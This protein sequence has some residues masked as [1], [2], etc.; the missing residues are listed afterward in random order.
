MRTR[1]RWKI[2]SL[3]AQAAADRPGVEVQS[4][5]GNA[6]SKMRFRDLSDRFRAL[7]EI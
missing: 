1:R 7:T 4:V 6:F 5:R 2:G 3:T